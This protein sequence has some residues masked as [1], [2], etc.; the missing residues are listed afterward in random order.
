L[1]LAAGHDRETAWLRTI[2]GGCLTEQGRYAA[3]AESLHDAVR[4]AD[5]S[6]A[7]DAGAFARSYVGRVHLLHGDLD[8]AADALEQ[9]LQQSRTSWL[10]LSPWPESLL[11]EVNLLAGDIDAAERAFERAFVMGRQLDDPCWESIATRGLGLVAVA[12]GQVDRG[13]GLL[14]DAP[15][16]L[17]RLPDTYLWIGGYGL[18]ALCRV[19]IE[20]RT[21]AAPRWI[22]ELEALAAR[23]GMRE[24]LARAMLH[25]ARLGEP[26]AFDAA[27]ELIASVD[28]PALKAELA[29]AVG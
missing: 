4:S 13:Y 6:H 28:N 3:A 9:S 16:L 11:A 19:G 22:A 26:A 24:L 17:R 2:E 21:A 8:A 1:A 10:A 25:R 12:R 29:E 15:R 14:V 5:A 7:A 18:D 23:C 20:H 27:Q